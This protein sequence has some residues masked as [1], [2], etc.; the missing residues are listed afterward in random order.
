[1]SPAKAGKP[2]TATP[3]PGAETL[4]LSGVSIT[5]TKPKLFTNDEEKTV[6]I[7]GKALSG[8]LRWAVLAWPALND[9]LDHSASVALE[10][11]GIAEQCRA[12]GDAQL[13]M[14]PIDCNAVFCSLG[15]RLRDLAHRINAFDKDW[16][17]L[18]SLTITRKPAE[19]A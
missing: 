19:V 8:L 1:M 7:K 17:K 6:T 2:R 14:I 3:K 18:E 4:P 5:I 10:L 15:D 9:D 11:V 12:M 13:E 16:N